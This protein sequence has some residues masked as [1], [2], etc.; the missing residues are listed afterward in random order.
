M[1]RFENV[2]K[3]YQDGFQALDSINL[4]IKQGELLVL[5]GPSGCGKTTTMRMI[6]RMNEPSSGKIFVDGKDISQENPVELRRN[7]GYVIQHIGLLPHMTIADNIAL[8][9]KL[10]KWDKSRYMQ[11]VNELLQLVNLDPD[12]YAQRYPSELSGGQQQ[13]VGVVRAMAADPAVILMDE[14]FSALDPISREQLQDELVRLQD[15]IQKTIVFVTHDIDEAIKIANRICIMSKGKIV[16]LDT[17]EHILR[18]PANDFVRSFIGENRLNEVGTR[19]TIAEI[20]V[21]PITTG[22]NRG[23]AE[24][25]MQMRRRK[26]DTLLV[27]DRTNTLLGRATVWDVQHHYFEENITL[28][29]ILRPD[30]AVVNVNQSLSDAIGLIREHRIAALPVVNDQNRLL[31]V[32]T[33]AS[34]VDV[35]AEQLGDAIS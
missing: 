9:P 17:P 22:P 27:V 5:I 25:I 14:P 26:V 15:T 23:L 8:V 16:Q 13:R 28:K 35:M 31:G 19:P 7:I 24:A 33:R 30:V 1:I 3:V 18:H 12:T 6:N 10:K 2:S 32:I 34:L 4:N 21:K 11:R 29:D 20:M